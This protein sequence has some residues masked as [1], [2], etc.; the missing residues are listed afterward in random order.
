[1]AQAI[2]AGRADCGIAIRAV[3]N[4]AGLDFV[5]IL[6]ER[7]DLVVRQRHYF[8][9]QLQALMRFLPSDGMAARAAEFGGYDLNGAGEVRFAP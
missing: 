7:F 2:R 5:P 4:A 3:A 8:R 1:V 9:P 6:W